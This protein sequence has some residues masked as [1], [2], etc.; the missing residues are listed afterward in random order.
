MCIRDSYS[1]G[2][3][4][5]FGSRP[6]N[7]CLNDL[8]WKNKFDLIWSTITL[9]NCSDN[10]KTTIQETNWDSCPIQA[11]LMSMKQT[12]SNS[13]YSIEG[14]RIFSSPPPKISMTQ[15]ASFPLGLDALAWGVQLFIVRQLHTT[16]RVRCIAWDM[17]WGHVRSSVC[18]SV[19]LSVC[20]TCVLYQTESV[21]APL[22]SLKI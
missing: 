6:K 19:C 21:C 3:L 7:V 5:K 16:R 13:Q 8:Q 18:L 11:E 9:S 2:R 4:P 1:I 14:H 10:V 17:L 15:L 12:L 22:V 20:H